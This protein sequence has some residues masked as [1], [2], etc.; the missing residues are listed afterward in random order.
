MVNR[1]ICG[2]NL[3]P[4]M[5]THF[6][7]YFTIICALLA[8]G[9]SWGEDYEL[10]EWSMREVAGVDVSVAEDSTEVF[11]IDSAPLSD[12]EFLTA[13]YDYPDS[14][15]VSDLG[16]LTTYLKPGGDTLCLSSLQNR[17][18]R[19]SPVFCG[20]AAF[21]G[22]RRVARHLKFGAFAEQPGRDS[23]M[24]TVEMGFVPKGR[25]AMVIDTDTLPSVQVVDS[26]LTA[27]VADS[28]AAG[29]V[30]RQ[31]VR[32]WFIAGFDFPIARE[33]TESLA[34][35]ADTVT[36]PA[37]TLLALPEMMAE[38][39]VEAVEASGRPSVGGAVGVECLAPDELLVSFA[40]TADGDE[41]VEIRVY[42]ILGRQL[43]APRRV[44]ASAAASVRLRL[45]SPVPGV[46]F[47]SVVSPSAMETV[48][49]VP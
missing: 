44:D 10:R 37:L 13:V 35:G 29:A 23:V 12:R 15:I 34:A 32:E 25:A 31:D 14:A 28:L 21:A 49:I 3:L 48:K 41:Q 43:V 19:L 42:D 6:I 47:V 33:L 46:F 7:A 1:Y 11:F 4:T 27:S 2:I 17:Q 36:A 5:K 8:P 26:Y 40:A 24:M 16:M 9:L 22:G 20:E 30:W 45:D 18:L 39:A 38:M